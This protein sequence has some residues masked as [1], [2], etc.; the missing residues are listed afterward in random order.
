MNYQDYPWRRPKELWHGLIAEILL[1]RTRA[2]NVVPVYLNIISHYKTLQELSSAPLS[3]IEEAIFPLGLAWRAPLIKE[4]GS[5]LAQNEGIITPDFQF[6]KNLPGVGN[7]VAS[8]WL[9]FHG[10]IRST[11]IDAN[12]VRFICRLTGNSMDGETRRKKWLI[13]YAKMLTPHD[14]WKTYNY[15]ILDFTMLICSKS[16]KCSICPLGANQCLFKKSQVKDS[17]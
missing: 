7:Y 15:A 4:L 14:E 9:S 6:L 5:V 13:D 10:G 3:E 2:K 17:K 16:P 12:V 1:Q 11:L 8:A